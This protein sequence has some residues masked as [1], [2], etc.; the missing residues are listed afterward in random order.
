DFRGRVV[1]LRQPVGVD[2]AEADR[3][4]GRVGGRRTGGTAGHADSGQRHVVEDHVRAEQSDVPAE[5]EGPHLLVA[6]G[7]VDLANIESGGCQ[8]GIRTDGRGGLL[9]IRA[10]AVV[11]NDAGI[12]P[13][14]GS[15]VDAVLCG[16]DA[17]AEG[18]GQQSV[19][20]VGDVVAARRAGARQTLDDPRGGYR[21][22]FTVR[23][24]VVH[25]DVARDAE[26]PVAVGRLEI[27]GA[28]GQ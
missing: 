23:V 17:E 13:E 21:R 18:R 11:G 14:V 25:V 9:Q 4:E 2:V 20:D 1:D 5:R 8:S 3:A 22:A 28:D 6:E 12:Q 7:H 15:D 19:A 16:R 27:D 24:D 26:R 10:A